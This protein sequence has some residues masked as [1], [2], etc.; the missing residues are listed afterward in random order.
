[1]YEMI[2][3]NLF[4]YQDRMR[5]RDRIKIKLEIL[6][7]EML[8]KSPNMTGMPGSNNQGDK[9]AE[10][11]VK[12]EEYTKNL[13]IAYDK[14]FREMVRIEALISLVDD[15]TLRQ[16]LTYRYLKGAKWEE[17]AEMMNYSEQRMYQLRLDALRAVSN[18]IDDRK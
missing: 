16:L 12:V 15:S 14:A 10:Y 9:M 2:E 17:I 8:P 13:Q 6:Q 3:K 18:V 11:I 7:N 4:A 5:E 1:M